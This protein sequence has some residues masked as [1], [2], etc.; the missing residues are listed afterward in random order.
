MRGAL[1]LIILMACVLTAGSWR[2]YSNTWDE[3]EHL[4]AGLEL[5]DRGHYEYDTE[6][7]PLARVLLALGPYLAGAHSFGTPPPDGTQEGKD[8][9]YTD[10]HYERFLLLARAGTLPFLVLLLLATWLWAR[11]LFAS[12]G[13][14]LLAVLLLVSVPPVLGHAALATPGRGRRGDHA[15]RPLCARALARQRARPDAIIFGLTG[16]IA[17]ATKFSAV[18]FIAVSLVALACFRAS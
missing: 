12:A 14:G 3:P 15:A 7:P 10:G 18:P 2:I 8:I 4:A 9:L 5:L 1:A 17:V 11:R 6:H 16:G 13:A